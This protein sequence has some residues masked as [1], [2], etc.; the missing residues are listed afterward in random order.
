MGR[1]RA[2]PRFASTASSRSSRPE[3]S[4][5]MRRLGAWYRSP[6]FRRQPGRS[7][8]LRDRGRRTAEEV[9]FG[10]A[11]R[12]N[13]A[14]EHRGDADRPGVLSESVSSKWVREPETLRRRA[15]WKS[16]GAPDHRRRWWGA[17][18]RLP[19]REPGPLRRQSPRKGQEN[20]RSFRFLAGVPQQRPPEGHEAPPRRRGGL[21]RACSSA[22]PPRA[23]R[24]AAV[25]GSRGSEEAHPSASL[26]DERRASTTC[27]RGGPFLGFSSG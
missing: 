23:R 17:P 1:L 7:P 20:P 26:P 19:D 25:T 9:T 21:P 14:K 5:G 27:L 4:R 13:F 2:P 12:S 11:A 6:E 22:A 10:P 18:E 24:N 3:R 16:S 15:C 8:G